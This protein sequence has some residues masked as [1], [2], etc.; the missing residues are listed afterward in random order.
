VLSLGRNLAL[1]TW[2]IGHLSTG[3][4]KLDLAITLFGLFLFLM[5]LVSAC[6]QKD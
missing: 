3:N 2:R 6:R 4:T 1:S 5:K